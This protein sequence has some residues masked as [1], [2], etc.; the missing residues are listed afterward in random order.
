MDYNFYKVRIQILPVGFA[1]LQDKDKIVS[2]DLPFMNVAD[3]SPETVHIRRQW[4]CV[5]IVNANG[6]V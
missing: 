3:C 1:H 2:H 4:S 6:G 5:W